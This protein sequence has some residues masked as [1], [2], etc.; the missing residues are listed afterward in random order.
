MH[1]FNDRVPDCP[2]ASDGKFV[3][4]KIWVGWS[5]IMV[6][7]L[8]IEGMTEVGSDYAGGLI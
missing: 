2:Q 3:A 8:L 1:S 6:S 4:Y 7:Q 5:L